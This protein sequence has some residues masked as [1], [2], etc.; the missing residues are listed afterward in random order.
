MN[1][2]PSS[3]VDFT[4]WMRKDPENK[5]IVIPEKVSW[6]HVD[7]TIPIEVIKDYS[8]NFFK[9]FEHSFSVQLTEI[10]NKG[11]VR[12]HMITLWKMWDRGGNV[13][14]VYAAQVKDSNDKWN[15]VFFQ[16]KN[17]KNLWVY[18]GTYQYDIN[19][20]YFFIVNRIAEN[21]RIIVF[22][23]D[24]RALKIEDSGFKAGVA[25]Y[26]R[27]LSVAAGINVNVDREDWSSGSIENLQITELISDSAQL[28]ASITVIKERLKIFIAYYRMTAGDYAKHLAEGL[29]DFNFDAFLDV[30]SIPDTIINYSD[31]WRE[32]RDE[33]LESSELF[34]L[35][36]TRGFEKADEVLYE[37]QMSDANNIEKLLMKRKRLGYTDLNVSFKNGEE[38]DLSEC[39]ILSFTN[40]EDLL[41]QVL[42]V[43]DA[44]GL[45]QI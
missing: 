11:P 7:R 4:E 2:R 24:E 13:L 15:I 32:I 10:E 18:S 3:Q 33:S 6:T 39:P 37:M 29:K 23:D 26:Y 43:L 30:W 45:I 35:I 34:I 5:F 21:C 38:Y 20:K 9:D 27:F 42:D 44:K 16:R 36:M 17:G 1:E 31:G 14:S 25:D 41:R 40:Q 22:E 12:R 8:E 19:K 28:P